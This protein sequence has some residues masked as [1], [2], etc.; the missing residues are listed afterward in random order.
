MAPLGFTFPAE[1]VEVLVK[2]GERVREGQVLIRARDEELRAQRDLQR[3]SA[4]TDL[5]VQ[6]AHAAM[7][8]AEVELTA[9][10]EIRTRSKAA[11]V[12]YAVIELER[13]KTTFILRQA[14]YGIAQLEQQQQQLQLA[15]RQAQL[16]R[17]Q[18]LSRFDG[19]VDEVL[20]HPGEVRRDSDPV[21][22]VVAT[23][24]L[25]MDVAAP[26]FQTIEMDLKPGRP[27]WVLMDLPGEARVFMGKVIEVAPTVD[28]A[29]RT[30]RVR[31]ELAN[32]HDWPAGLNAWV[33]FTEP[34]AE[35]QAR[36]VKP[37]VTETADRRPTAP[38]P[39]G[40]PE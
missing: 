15:F 24:P 28:S 18:L 39:A 9:Q 35:W 19:V 21:I 11:T 16:D 1:I 7:K 40:A 34:S 20:V 33:R 4:E 32:P 25:W 36:I 3:L 6:R 37:Q 26:A 17:L 27:A 29:S 12:P 2:G 5:P 31:V 13:A 14:E 10:E 30:R 38:Q 23:D 8:Q 22:R